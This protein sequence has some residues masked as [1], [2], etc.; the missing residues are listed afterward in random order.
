MSRPKGFK[1]NK[2]IGKYEQT[3][4]TGI[5]QED[6]TIQTEKIETLPSNESRFN[7]LETDVKKIGE[8]L[9]YLVDY[10]PKKEEKKVETPTSLEK[11]A[12]EHRVPPDSM[13]PISWTNKKNEI[14]GHEVDMRV[15]SSNRGFTLF[16]ILPKSLDR[17]V[18][19][20]QGL[21]T[22]TGFIRLGQELSDIES[23]CNKVKN[24][25][26][27]TYPNFK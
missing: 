17:R 3:M 22:S 14:L 24:N 16:L 23:V 9:A 21:D 5:M 1:K 6:G 26:K 25:I 13:V 7:A 27:L 10:L 19:E 20:R 4:S 11:L 2:E 12:D 18:G 15:E 8:M